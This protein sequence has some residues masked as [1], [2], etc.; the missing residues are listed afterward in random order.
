MKNEHISIGKAAKQLGVTIQTLRRWD[1][2]GKLRA[3]RSDSGY[4]YYSQETLD[5]YREDLYALAQA[6][7]AS[8]QPGIIP[9]KFYADIAPRFQARQ[10]A[11]GILMEREHLLPVDTV[12]LLTAIVGEI[13]D[14]A[15]THNIGNWP[16]A[17][18]I[19]FAYDL[20]KRE[21][22]V[23]DR[24]RGVYATLKVVAPEITSDKDALRV[25]LTKFISGRA[26]EKRGNGLKFVREVIIEHD[27]HLEFQSGLAIARISKKTG[28]QIETAEKNIR[29]TIAKITF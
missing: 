10:S 11:M 24:G 23:A 21:V 12:S 18:G 25:A 29:G 6:W 9:E 27:F 2:S 15:F 28:L 17:T 13:G 19:F 20:G 4:R 7:A 22:I 8:A 14:N 1:E 26:P 3:E 5:L 16:D